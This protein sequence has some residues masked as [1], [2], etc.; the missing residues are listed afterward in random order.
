MATKF[1]TRQAGK[2]LRAAGKPRGLLV[3]FRGLRS[4]GL[5]GRFS[6]RT[7]PI[8]NFALF[9]H[10]QLPDVDI[11]L[12]DTFKGSM[13][14]W[15]RPEDLVAA[16]IAT[17]D[18]AD[19]QQEYKD[20]R[21]IGYSMGAAMARKTLIG[22]WGEAQCGVPFEEGF[23]PPGGERDWPARVSRLVSI[24]G[25]ARGWIDNPRLSVLTRFAMNFYGFIGH[26]AQLVQPG[27]TNDQAAPLIFR[28]RRGAPFIVNTRLQWLGLA[29]KQAPEGEAAP[30]MA[31]VHVMPANDDLISSVEVIDVEGD[32][33][34]KSVHYMT[35]PDS[36]HASVLQFGTELQTLAPRTLSRRKA[37][38][39]KFTRAD[40]LLSALCGKLDNDPNRGPFQLAG[41]V[42]P[43]SEGVSTPVHYLSDS[44]PSKPDDYVERFVFIIHGI[45][46]TGAWA[47]KIGAELQ[48]QNDALFPVHL[49]NSTLRTDTQSYGYFTALPFLLP[50]LRK[51]K[52]EWLMDRYA[53]A[54]ALY[55]KAKI[56]FVG[57]S[58][59]TYLAAS[60]LQDYEMCGFD[61]VALA[62]SVVREDFDW[63]GLNA[64]RERVGPVVNYVAT[65]DFIVALFPYGVRKIFGRLFDLGGA[66]HVG[67]EGQGVHN[68]RYA[69]GGHSAGIAEHTWSKTAAF[70]LGGEVPV[71]DPLDNKQFSLRQ[72]PWALAL[73][74]VSWLVLILGLAVIVSL[75]WSLAA[76]LLKLPSWSPIIAL[77]GWLGSAF[78]EGSVGTFFSGRAAALQ[79]LWQCYADWSAVMQA[80]SL[81][82][83]GWLVRFA[84]FRF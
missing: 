36:D 34:I 56:S 38:D 2:F 48:R 19:R 16:S 28:L 18:E 78:G 7:D 8:E 4:R 35:V 63:A 47:K 80:I 24:A 71:A 73:G 74:R 26:I 25:Y 55:P 23:M 59:G 10:E 30:G 50:W 61:R 39:L 12:L 27:R 72:S 69:V 70:I 60:A 58:N 13:L 46:D 44:I 37:S 54:R 57:H 41:A 31:V 11:L 82:I 42:P 81:L 65:R 68:V 33:Q 14:S 84:L 64:E 49:S 15:R 66:G 62:G 20:I 3:M 1:E 51:Q 9:L 22:G 45:R 40:Y 17:I 53:T 79:S 43:D 32:E 21:F 67:F 75:G 77:F 29:R 76:P 5:L 6:W 83:Y 52:V